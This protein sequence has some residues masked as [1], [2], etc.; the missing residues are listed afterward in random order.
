[1]ALAV[2][3][4]IAVP[5]PSAGGPKAESSRDTCFGA[6]AHD[7]EHPCSDPALQ[8]TVTPTPAE[9]RNAKNAPCTITV[10]R[11]PFRVCDFGV[12]RGN[13]RATVA[14]VGDSHAAH[15]RAALEVV[16]QAER[17]HG[18]SVTLSGC[19]Y[20]VS[21]RVLREPLLSECGRRNREVP[22]WLGR[23]EEIHTIFVSE[24]SGARWLLPR[25]TRDRFRAESNA[26]TAAW[27]RLPPSV[28]HIV[29]IRDTPKALPST[30]HCIERAA[31]LGDDAGRACAVN[32]RRAIDP[33]AAVAAAKRLGGPRFATVDMNR[34]FCNDTVCEPVIGGVLV[35]KDL[36]HLTA[37]FVRTLGPYLVDAVRGLALG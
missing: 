20:S 11:G 7:P 32:R 21:T 19:P 16:A 2:A 10:S 23:N 34:Y 3:T 9:A 5:V 15:W 17:W 28:R 4:A 6:A 27:R 37:V 25:S 26:Y 35:Q 36:H 33:D 31:A 1:L 18:V 22:R 29:V 24:L 13:A 12:P 8:R 30:A 14:L